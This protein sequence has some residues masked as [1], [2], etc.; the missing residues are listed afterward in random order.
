MSSPSNSILRLFMQ[1]RDGASEAKGP[2]DFGA[3]L[4]NSKDDDDGEDEDED[5]GR[6]GS[7]APARSPNSNGSDIEEPQVR[8]VLLPMIYRHS[9][10][11]RHTILEK[12]QPLMQ[13]KQPS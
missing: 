2:K 4:S 12:H 1:L 11:C 3:M 5:P 7:A 13:S 10:L 6:G 9:I 8:L